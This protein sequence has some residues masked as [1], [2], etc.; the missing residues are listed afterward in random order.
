MPGCALLPAPCD[1]AKDINIKTLVA[2]ISDTHF[3]GSTALAPPA[4]ETSEGQVVH[5]SP[6]QRWL[7]ECWLDYWAYVYGLT[8]RNKARLVV[9]H[10]GDVVDGNHH[11]SVQ[12]LPNVEDQEKMAF[13]MLE[14]MALKADKMIIMRG[15]EAHTGP[16]GMSENSIAAAL[17]A[18]IHWE[19]LLDV[20]GLLLDLAHHGKA[21]T[22]DWT[23]SAAATAVEARGRA[24]AEGNPIPAYVFRGDRHTVDDSGARVAGTRAMTAPAWQLKTSYGHRAAAGKR[25]DI[26]GIIVLPDGSLDLSKLRYMAGE[27]S[28]R[29][30]IV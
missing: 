23:S 19:A 18:E 9:I 13:E 24:L 11:N 2:V 30:M 15:T 26:G 17:G 27:G 29:V 22:R 8:K 14:P 3:G 7:H 20:G 12:L 21:G 25:S 6:A 10:L 16:M 4:F 5:A 1:T 28:R